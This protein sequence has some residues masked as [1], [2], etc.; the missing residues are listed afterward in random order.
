M[1]AGSTVLKKRKKEAGTYLRV[2]LSAAGPWK[3]TQLR[4][5]TTVDVRSVVFTCRR[6]PPPPAL[7]SGLPRHGRRRWTAAARSCFLF[8]SEKVNH[9]RSFPF[10]FPPPALA[11]LPP[12]PQSS[13]TE[14]QRNR[15]SPRD[16]QTKNP[17]P[18]AGRPRPRRRPL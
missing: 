13:V 2:T 3:N 4:V 6:S 7:T 14:W 12:P 11:P 9:H 10:F 17:V 5:N 1:R 8:V 16:V 15:T 18:H